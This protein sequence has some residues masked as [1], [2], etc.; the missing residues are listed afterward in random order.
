MESSRSSSS[1][2]IYIC[3]CISWNSNTSNIFSITIYFDCCSIPCKS[4]TIP[5]I[6][7]YS[8]F[9]CDSSIC[10]IIRI[11]F[12]LFWI[13]S[14][15][16]SLL[17]ISSYIWYILLSIRN[18]FHSDN[19]CEFRICY[20]WNISNWWIS[21]AWI[22]KISCIITSRNKNIWWLCSSSC[23]SS[24]SAI[25]FDISIDSSIIE[26]IVCVC[27]CRR[28]PSEICCNCCLLWW[29]YRIITINRKCC[30]VICC[31]IQHNHTEIWALWNRIRDYYAVVYF[32][33]QGT[34]KSK[35]LKK[36]TKISTKLLR[37]TKK[38][39][40]GQNKKHSL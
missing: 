30:Y 12:Y 31:F 8:W 14:I 28:M 5:L 2:N 17:R 1:S 37:I 34:W 23:I 40:D 10:S 18:W 16:Y 21:R 27:V 13:V 22:V 25:I 11:K 33:K 7:I 24:I 32:I 35:R 20:S 19:F 4:Y 26:W 9:Y 39:G 6:Q 38:Q 3:D 15:N 29:N 36:S